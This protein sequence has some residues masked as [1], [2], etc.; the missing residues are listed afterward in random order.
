MTNISKS[1]RADL[2][3]I[4]E[5]KLPEIVLDKASALMFH[6]L[7]HCMHLM[8][9]SGIS[10]YLNR[11]H[12]FYEILSNAGMVVMTRKTRGDDIDAACGQLAG[13]VKDR[14][15]RKIHFAKLEQEI[16]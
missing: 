3:E 1:M 12:K 14:S 6:W 7:F 8:M 16:T 4:A 11:I 13:E 15:R 2:A 5:I 10:W 9:H